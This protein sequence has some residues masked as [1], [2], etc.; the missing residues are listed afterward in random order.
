[1]TTLNH[2]F[3]F[4]CGWFVWDYERKLKWSSNHQEKEEKKRILTFADTF[5]NSSRNRQKE[6]LK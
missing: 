1:M 2:I 3:R 6:K 4:P 5:F